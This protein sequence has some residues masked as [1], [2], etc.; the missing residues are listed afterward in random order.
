MFILKIEDIEKH[1]IEDD[2]EDI[3]TQLFNDQSI[4]ETKPFTNA[5]L[6]HNSLQTP[7]RKMQLENGYN[8]PE[9]VHTVSNAT[10]VN[11]RNNSHQTFQRNFNNNYGKLNILINKYVDLIFITVWYNVT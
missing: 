4:L 10:T 9:V 5:T 6:V 3:E 1:L 11:H 7:D 2:S 8:S